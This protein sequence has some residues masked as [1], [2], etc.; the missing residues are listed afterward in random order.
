M[1]TFSIWL[2]LCLKVNCVH[3]LTI[4]RHVL[5][6]PT[7]S[8]SI[9]DA[10]AM[11]KAYPTSNAYWEDKRAD[12]GKIKVPAYIVTSYTSGLHTAGTLR[13]YE[14]MTAPRWYVYYLDFIY[15]YSLLT[16][17]GLR[18]TTPK[19]C[20]IYTVLKEYKSYH[21]SSIVISRTARTIGSKTPESVLRCLVSIRYVHPHISPNL[22]NQHAKAQYK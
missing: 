14:E 18:S 20:M 15:L 6:Y 8:G 22:S 16:N 21:D 9:E 5:T 3:F 19:H 13:C 4:T 10:A 7:G 2:W 17:L 11:M 1:R 12:F